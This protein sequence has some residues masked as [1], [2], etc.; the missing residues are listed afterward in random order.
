MATKG[1]ARN[2]Q[3]VEST[4]TANYA[5]PLRKQLVWGQVRLAARAAIWFDPPDVC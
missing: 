1:D 4:L 2:V 3:D 5:E